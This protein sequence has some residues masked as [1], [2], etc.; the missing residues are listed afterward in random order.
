MSLLIKLIDPDLDNFIKYEKELIV[1]TAHMNCIWIDSYQPENLCL[2]CFGI[3]Y[4]N[5]GCRDQIAHISQ[6]IEKG[7]GKCDSIVAWY[8]AVYSYYGI[9][10]A[11]VL[12]QRSKDELHAQMEATIN[13]NRM[14]LDPSINIQKLDREFC[15]RCNR[16]GSKNGMFKK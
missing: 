12:V 15:K 13:G 14:L 5:D 2:T 3:R 8:M 4:I 11:P 6:M 1:A 9:S 10:T 7:F 16:K